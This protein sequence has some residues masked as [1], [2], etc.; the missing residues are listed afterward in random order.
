MMNKISRC[1]ICGQFF[2]SKKDLKEHKDNNH[3][4]TNTKIVQL[5]GLIAII[6]IDWLSEVLPAASTIV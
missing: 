2:D 6:T 4:I 5:K 3:R 1:S